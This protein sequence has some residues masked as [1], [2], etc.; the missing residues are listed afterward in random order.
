MEGVSQVVPVTHDHRTFEAKPR[1]GARFDQIDGIQ[2]HM[3][4]Q[5]VPARN[6]QVVDSR[7]AGGQAVL[8]H[9]VSGAYHELNS[10]G[11]AIWERVDGLRTEAEIA[12]EVRRLV[13]DPPD[14]LE[15]VITDFLAEMRKRDLVS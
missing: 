6:P 10:V 14:D 1:P 15:A 2:M 7:L 4:Q 12:E 11:A 13:E 9:L 8:L 3:V 5:S